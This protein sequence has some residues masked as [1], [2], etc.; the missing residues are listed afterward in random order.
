MRGMK[1][2]II[3]CLGDQTRHGAFF[4]FDPGLSDQ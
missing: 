2:G 4:I 1:M 3:S